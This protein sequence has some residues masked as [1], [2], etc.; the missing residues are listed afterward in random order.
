MGDSAENPTFV[1]TVA[2]RGYRFLAP[3]TTTAANGNGSLAVALSTTDSSDAVLPSQSPRHSRAWWIVAAVSAVVLVLVGIKLGL[4]LSSRP[5]PAAQV[6]VTRLTANPANDPV[7]SAGISRDGK[8]LAFSDETGFYL[9][10]IDTAETH[11]LPLPQGLKVGYLSWFPDSVHMVAVLWGPDQQSSLWEIS[12]LGGGAR[13]LSDEGTSPAVAPDGKSI[14]F[15]T[16]KKMR[17]ELWLMDANGAQ[18]HKLVG[19]E[20]D[21][22]GAVTWSPDGTRLA[23]TRG[24]IFYDFGVR[25]GIEFLDVLNHRVTSLRNIN[26]TRWFDNLNGPLTWADGHLI[27]SLTEQ[28]PRQLDSNLWSITVDRSG[29][30]IGDPV[31]MTSDPGAVSSIS[32]STDGKRVVYVKGVPQPDVYVARLRGRDLVGEPERLTL[33]DRQDLPFDWTTDNK[34]VIFISDRTGVLSIYRQAVDETVPELL[35]SG[36]EPVI[37]PRLSPDGT[38]ILY[39]IYPSWSVTFPSDKSS[40]SISLMRVPLAGGA[41][42]KVLQAASI[43]NHQCSRA[44]ATLCLYSVAEPVALAFFSYDPMK[45]SG[46]QVYQLKDEL[47][48][49]FNWSLS[50]DG[51]MLAIS[52]S[53]EANKDTQIHLVSLKTAT[54]KIITVQGW[55]GLAS[56]DW[57]SDSKSL[58][59]PSVGDEENPL[60]NIDLQGNARPVWHPRKLNARWAIPSR[61]GKYLAIHV[62]SNSANVWMLERP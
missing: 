7:H 9:R 22:F 34:S 62:A 36:K 4:L 26:T 25:G 48:Q 35:V 61:D 18:P 33:D 57:A 30:A 8:Y 44:P 53:K 45:G 1:E 41:P 58:W 32:S 38:Q 47:P 13:K 28:A 21:F 42:R 37:S 43:S 23:Y 3:V 14:A 40:S 31:R 51:T 46:A 6:R 15:I 54:E 29:N 16:G 52:K 60:L 20:G 39:L 55:P 2:R 11:P 59:A 19:E 17:E 10:Q 5:A 12:A 50:P 24:R 27:C 56:L 49:L